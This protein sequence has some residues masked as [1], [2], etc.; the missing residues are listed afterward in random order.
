MDGSPCA[1]G[2]GGSASAAGRS[3]SRCGGFRV[4]GNDGERGGGG[5]TEP[6]R[7]A[8]KRPEP[9]RAEPKRAEPKKSRAE[10][11]RAEKSRA[12]KRSRP[13]RNRSLLTGPSAVSALVVHVCDERAPSRRQTPGSELRKPGLRIARPRRREVKSALQVAVPRSPRPR[14]TSPNAQ[15]RS[16]G[17]Q[18]PRSWAALTKSRA[19]ATA[20]T[21]I[22]II[23]DTCIGKTT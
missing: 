10:K 21:G 15:A 20:R 3:G 1:R 23:S 8:P 12:E 19:P 14:G 2:W 7:A 4:P 13:I 16:G 11:S 5:E 9:K 22:Q 6:K 18:E 17:A